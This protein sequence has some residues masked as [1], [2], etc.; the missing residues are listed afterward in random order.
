MGKVYLVGAGTGDVGLITAHGKA[1]VEKADCIL[2]DRLIGSELLQLADARCEKIYVGKAQHHHTV[3]Q[4]EI[5]R[6]LLEK[7]QQ[8]ETVVRLKGGDPYV[9]GRGAEE[10]LF[11][12]EHGVDTEVVSGVSSVTA[13]LAY[14]GIPATKRGVAT[15]F[16]AVTAHTKEDL[17]N[18][19]DFSTMLNEKETLVF[20]MGLRHLDEIAQALMKAG[21]REETPV[22][23][24]ANATTPRQKKCVGTLESI[25]A[26]VKA[27]GLT[28]PA[29]IVVGDVVRYHSCLSFYEKKRLFGKKY[30]LPYIEGI[31]Y[32]FRHGLQPVKQSELQTGLTALGA[33]AVPYQVGKINRISFDTGII[34]AG[35]WLVFTSKNAVY[36]VMSQLGDLRKIAGCRIAAVGRKTAAVLADF[37]IAADRIAEK[38]TVSDLAKQLTGEQNLICFTE[39]NSPGIPDGRQVVCYEN[40]A[41]ATPFPE[42]AKDCDGVLFTCASSV[43][44]TWVAADG[45]LPEKIY[46]IGPSCSKELQQHGITAFAEAKEP[47]YEQLIAL[48]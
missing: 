24:I 44:R 33:A 48:L 42:E 25:A 40:A 9:F 23:V 4:A 13:A 8:Y 31:T 6:L 2:Y 47:S 11:L 32:S 37:G 46:S 19:I 27:Q 5:Q 38:G 30:L 17:L 34:E 1:L 45:I 3:P 18:N 35:Q 29:I 15:G 20:L 39:K 41:V 26:L 14:A 12:Q 21:R 16:R 10:A 36:S 28:S 43:R 7:A 22:A